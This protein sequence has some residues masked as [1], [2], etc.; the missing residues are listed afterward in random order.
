LGA[1]AERELARVQRRAVATVT[2]DD[3]EAERWL[4]TITALKRPKGWR[5]GAGHRTSWL[6]ARGA[7]DDYWNRWLVPLGSGMALCL[8]LKVR[9]PTLASK[10]GARTRDPLRAPPVAVHAR[11]LY[12]R[13]H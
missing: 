3:E 8:P 5:K 13:G 4:W 9:A 2:R 10:V 11:L 1:A 6:D 7:A 12:G